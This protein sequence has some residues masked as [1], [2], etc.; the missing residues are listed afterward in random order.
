MTS[1]QKKHKSEKVN[2]ISTL[3]TN[4]SNAFYKKVYQKKSF[5]INKLKN[6]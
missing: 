1:L 5:I 3:Q 6:I 4:N 2:T